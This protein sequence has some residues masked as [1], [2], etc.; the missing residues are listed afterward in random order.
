MRFRPVDRADQAIGEQRNVEPEL[1]RYRVD[2]L[3]VLSEQ[4]Q[5]QRGKAAVM[6]HF[7]DAAI[8]G[9]VTA[10]S[11]TVREDDESAGICRNRQVAVEHVAGKIQPNR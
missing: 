11:T 7:S 2:A 9:A 6:Q 1:R 3:L 5:K 8:A 10:A 4:V